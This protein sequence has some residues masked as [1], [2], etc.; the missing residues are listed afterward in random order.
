MDSIRQALIH[1]RRTAAYQA[2][3]LPDIPGME[4]LAELKTKLPDIP[5]VMISAHG[6]TR[7]AVQAVKSGAT[8][9]LTKPFELDDVLHLI[10]TSAEKASLAKE[11]S[12]LRQKH[13]GHSLLLGNSAIMK[14]LN[15]KITKIAEST[16]QRVLLLGDSGTGKTLAAKAIHARSSRAEGPYVEINCAALPDQL[17]EAELFGAEKGSYTGAS[18]RRQGLVQLA[19]NGTLFLDEIG[20]LPPNL[21][22]KLLTFLDNGVYRPIGSPREYSSNVRIVTATNRNITELVENG[23]FREELYYRLNVM[24]IQMPTLYERRDDLTILLEYFISSYSQAE[25]CKKIELSPEAIN[26]LKEYRWPGNIRELRNLIERFTILYPN[27]TVTPE[28]LPPEFSGIIGDK[29]GEMSIQEHVAE[30]E[31]ELLIEAI[32]KAEGKKQKAAEILGISRHALKRRLQKY[33]LS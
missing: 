30:K 17:L 26:I 16:T 27:Q 29:N 4:V 12:Y 9:Y 5:V 33:G 24:T 22:A 23:Q 15:E 18:T 8:D 6:D 11:V 25:G 10:R 2:L 21:Q 14:S 19:D 31:K 32:N 20:E 7:T 1:V 3:K 13:F 28:Y